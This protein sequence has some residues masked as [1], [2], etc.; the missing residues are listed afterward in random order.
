MSYFLEKG[1]VVLLMST[2]HLSKREVG[3]EKKPD[4]VM[5]CNRLKDGVNIMDQFVATALSE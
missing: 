2:M 3:S 4:V 5:Y 1:K